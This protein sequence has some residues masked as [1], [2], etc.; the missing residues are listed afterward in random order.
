MH[1]KNVDLAKALVL[2]AE[3]L[4][5]RKDKKL[6][7]TYLRKSLRNGSECKKCKTYIESSVTILAT[8]SY[9]ILYNFCEELGRIFDWSLVKIKLKLA[10]G[11]KEQ[12]IKF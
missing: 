5:L 7:L 3:S 10:S 9:R 4:M 2:F 8:V 6:F 11:R 1:H 12:K